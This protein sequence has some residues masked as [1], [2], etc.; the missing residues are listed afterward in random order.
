MTNS[1]Y[2][3]ALEHKRDGIEGFAAKYN[4]TRLVYY[5]S[6]DDVTKAIDREKELKRWVRRKKIA[7]ID[8]EIHDGL[9][10]QNIGV[11]SCCLPVNQ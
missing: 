2:R 4:C 5:E 11:R 1:I 7:L 6:F 8:R 10:W 3:R 9:I